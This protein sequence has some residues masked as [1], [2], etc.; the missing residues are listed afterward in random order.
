MTDVEQR[1]L[2]VKIG[3]FELAKDMAITVLSRK[4]R[5]LGAL[6]HNE[7]KNLAVGPLYHCEDRPTIDGHYAKFKYDYILLDPTDTSW[8]HNWTCFNTS[9]LDPTLPI[10][11]P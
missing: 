3:M 8:P 10:S 5:E 2:Q 11:A 4:L 6:A 1:L 9:E 7:G